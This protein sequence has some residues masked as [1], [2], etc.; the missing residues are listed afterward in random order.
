MGARYVIADEPQPSTLQQWVVDPMWPFFALMLGGLW[1]ALPWSVFNG[2]ALG[3]P[4][5]RSE[6]L[7][8]GIALLG[9]AL[10]L[11]L[12]V[13]TVEA[14]WIAGVWIQLSLLSLTALKLAMGFVVYQQQSRSFE[15]WRHFGGVPRNAL[16]IVIASIFAERWLFQQFDHI[17][18]KLV[19]G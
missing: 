4:T 2:I 3:S 13:L 8:L 9:S 7:A 15:L 17:Y 14:G 1:L 5:R 11:W 12:L 6:W 19:L 18:V 10:L 16:L